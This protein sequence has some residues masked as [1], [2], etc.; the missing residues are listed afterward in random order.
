VTLKTRIEYLRI[1]LGLSGVHADRKT[2]ELI[3]KV[4]EKVL[5][6]KGD[7][8]ILDAVTIEQQVL[9]KRSRKKIVED[10]KK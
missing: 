3:I 8:D 2:T 7:F 6:K 10:K 5:E 9:G 4:Y 1:A